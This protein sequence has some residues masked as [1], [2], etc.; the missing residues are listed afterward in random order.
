MNK[1]NIKEKMKQIEYLLNE[2]KKLEFERNALSWIITRLNE[3]F[4]EVSITLPD[5]MIEEFR[6]R[7]EVDWDHFLQKKLLPASL[8]NKSIN[9]ISKKWES[10]ITDYEKKIEEINN[11]IEEI[12]R[13]LYL[14]NK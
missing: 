1:E 8:D 3:I 2:L 6:R 7:F 10:K 13:N 12:I 9:V 14:Q 5:D 11:K 4:F